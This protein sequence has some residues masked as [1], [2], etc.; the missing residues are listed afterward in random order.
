MSGPVS[1]VET[2]DLLDAEART[3]D[4]LPVVGSV[5]RRLK[6]AETIDERVGVDPRNLVSAGEAVE[7]MVTTILMGCHTLYLVEDYLE[8]Y[9][10]ELVF[11]W[12]GR[13]EHFNDNRLAKALDQV[14]ASGVQ[15]LYAALLGNAIRAFNLSVQALHTDTTSATVHGAYWGSIEPQDPEDPQAIPHVTYGHSKD[16]RPDLKQ[17]LFGLT[18][19]GDGAVPIWGRVAS[20]SRADAKEFRHA[21]RQIAEVVPDPQDSVVVLDSKGFAGETQLLFREHGVGYVTIMPKS[22][23]LWTQLQERFEADDQQS[24]RESRSLLRVNLSHEDE[25]GMCKPVETARWEGR[26]YPCTYASKS[27]SGEQHEIPLRALVVE[28]T[29]LRGKKKLTQERA[30]E[31]E[32]KSLERKLKAAR[33][34]TFS[35]EDDAGS[36][37]RELAGTSLVYFGLDVKVVAEDRPK[38]RAKAGRPKKD[39]VVETER[40]WRLAAETKEPDAEK[41]ALRLDR[42]CRFVIV[43]CGEHR[44]T[45]KISEQEFFELYHDQDKVEK[46]MKW[47]KGPLR[48][49]PIFL[50]KPERVAALGVVYVV[51]LMV[52]ALI[53]REIRNQLEARG[54]DI[55]GNRGVTDKPT[56][57]VVFR[58]LQGIRTLRHPDS[59]QVVI[60]NMHKEQVHVFELLGVD[61]AALPGVRIA[62]LR[63]VRQGRRGARPVPRDHKQAPPRKSGRREMT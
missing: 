44:L 46:T 62:S 15:G 31:K 4:H 24:G 48:V 28:S 2:L 26:A 10:C 41:L 25:A 34:K 7:A 1:E 58:L 17:V 59:S 57:Q 33:T 14:F 6:L 55:P 13:V 21:L 12:G 32:R 53:Q 60:T 61:L 18:V 11:P 22:V 54:E 20:G 36:A 29:A 52:N 27:E 51:S 47:L 63:T 23:G 38:K 9:D 37:A 8:P 39:E 3:L 50:E 35:C 30:V 56:T 43:G 40:V 19:T 49:A 45:Q 16:H 42:A 5:L